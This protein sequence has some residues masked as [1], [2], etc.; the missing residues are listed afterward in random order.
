MK[1]KYKSFNIFDLTLYI[2]A[3]TNHFFQYLLFH[4]Y[5]R[6]YIYI[7]MRYIYKNPLL[8]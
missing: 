1:N 4:S 2:F 3:Y 6:L 8:L 5:L 7:S